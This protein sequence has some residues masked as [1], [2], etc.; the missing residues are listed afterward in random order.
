LRGVREED[1][2]EGW[3]LEDAVPGKMQDEV[4]GGEV[5][6][7]GEARAD[8]LLVDQELVVIPAEAGAKGPMVEVDEVLDPRGLI[9]LGALAG[10]GKS[11]RSAGIELGWVGDGVIEVFVEEGIVGFDAKLPLVA[12]AVGGELRI[13]VAFSKMIVL[14]DFDRRGLRV[15]V[16]VVRVVGPCRGIRP[17]CWGRRCARTML[18]LRF[19]GYRRFGAGQR[20]AAPLRWECRSGRARGGGSG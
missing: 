11:G 2:L 18:R 20:P 7:Q 14:G 12:V 8:G 1:V 17:G 5:A 6:G 9:Y 19:R 10:E 4:A 16:E 13:R 15:G 3:G